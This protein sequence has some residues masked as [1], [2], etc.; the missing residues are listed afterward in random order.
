M[1][2]RVLALTALS[3][4]PLDLAAAQSVYVAPGG[5][6]I[7][8]ANVYVVPPGNGGSIAPPVVYGPSELDPAAIYPNGNGWNGSNGVYGLN[9]LNGLNGHSS[10]PP[11]YSGPLSAYAARPGARTGSYIVRE[12]ARLDDAPR[13]PAPIPYGGRLR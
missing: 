13:P 7:G 12:R 9:G 6:Y 5:V 2:Y 3:L 4:A 1:L 11:A 8:S 10:Y